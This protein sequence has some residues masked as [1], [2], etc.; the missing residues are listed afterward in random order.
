MVRINVIQKLVYPTPSKIILLLIDGLG[1][2]PSEEGGKTPLEAASIPN[3]D[4]L[5]KKGICGLM[6]PI[7]TGITPGSGPSHLALFGYDP[8]KYDIGRGV[9][10]ALG[11]GLGMTKK[12]VAT[13][14]NFATINEEGIIT[15][16]R[17][18]R[19]SSEKCRELCELLQARIK[20]IDDVEIVIKPSKEHRFVVLFRGEGLSDRISDTDPQKDG[21]PPKEPKSLHTE[22]KKTEKIVT[23]FTKRSA[24]LLK[25]HH[26]SNFVL[27][28]GF[29]KY[30]DIPYMNKLFKIRPAA[31][32][33]YPMYKGLARLVGMEIIECGETHKEE[34]KS[35]KE[36]YPKYD[37]FYVH[38]K[39]TDKA[40]EDGNFSSKTEVLEE[41]DRYIPEIL[42]LKPE[43]FV[44][45]G[46]HS[47]P[48]KLKSHSWHPNPL[49]LY[50]Q[51][52]GADGVEKFCERECVKGGLG[53]LDATELMP[54]MLA[55]ALKLKKYGA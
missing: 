8:F 5:T 53:R 34:I 39:E 28:R 14:A 1:D 47:T 46:D 38:I 49:I 24:E 42:K 4:E 23:E 25:S 17:A 9:L 30:P 35:L 48:C 54:L 21:H 36:N 11:I 19:I 3:M 43:C 2:I 18:G 20:S 27:L 16:R 45:T 55:N 10:E 37:F 7:S 29:A 31:I 41:V 12:D 26:P 15:D 40:G 33:T 32:A 50:S 44:I 6:D 13:R 52:C 51:Y 22:A